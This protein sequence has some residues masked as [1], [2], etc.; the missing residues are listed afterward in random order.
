MVILFFLPERHRTINFIF[1][2]PFLNT[3]DC[4]W[5]YY[6]IIGAKPNDKQV[7]TLGCFMELRHYKKIAAHD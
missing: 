4:R 7:I 5:E 2:Y 1:M 6:F 3:E